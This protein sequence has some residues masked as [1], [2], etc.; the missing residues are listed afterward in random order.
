[1]TTMRGAP[2]ASGNAPSHRLNLPPGFQATI[3]A[4]VGGGPRFMALSPDGQVFVTLQQAGRVVELV[5]DGNG[6][7]HP[8]TI[9]TGLDQPHG[10]AFHGGYLYVGETNQVVRWPYSD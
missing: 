6:F 2:D 10:I 4:S 8:E 7:A 9:L 3:Y 1:A 5:D